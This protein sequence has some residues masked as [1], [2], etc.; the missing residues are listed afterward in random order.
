LFTCARIPVV[1]A[2][3]PIADTN[4]AAAVASWMANLTTAA[5]TY[6]NIADWNTA[7]VT[8]MAS[9]FNGTAKFNDDIGGWN[10][11]AVANMN[12]MFNGAS[13]FSRNLAGWNVLAVTDFT[14]TFDGTALSGCNYAGAIYTAWGTA[15]QTLW[16]TFNAETCT[17]ESLCT[18]CITNGNIGMAAV[19]WVTSPSAAAVTYGNIVDWNTAAVTSMGSLFASQ[20]TFNDDISSWN[21]VSVANMA[22][23]FNGAAA[24]N[25]YIGGWNVASA[26]TLDHM[27]ASATAFNQD[28]GGW[29]VASVA[30]FNSMFFSAGATFNRNIGGWNLSSATDLRYMFSSGAKWVLSSAES[31][32][33]AACAS[34]S[35]SCSELSWPTSAAAMSAAFQTVGK[36]CGTADFKIEQDAAVP[37]FTTSTSDTGQP[38]NNCYGYTGNSTRCSVAGATGSGWTRLCACVSSPAAFNQ[39]IGGWNVARVSNLYGM[40]DGAAGFSQN[41]GSWNVATVANLATALDFASGLSFGSKRAMYMGWGS[42]LQT[43]YPSWGLVDSN[44]AN[45]VTWWMNAPSTAAA[46][47]GPIGRWDTSAVTSFA[48]LFSSKPAFNDDISSWNTASVTT[49]FRMFASAA[50][51]SQEIYRWNVLSVTS[52]SAAFQDV[53]LSSCTKAFIYTAWGSTLQLEYPAWGSFSISN[54]TRRC[55]KWRHADSMMPD[56]LKGSLAVQPDTIT[57]SVAYFVADI[58]VRPC[59]QLRI[60][61]D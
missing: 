10:T 47:Y 57:D 58:G 19:A 2:Q 61:A 22:S 8:T 52:V 24:F 25:S 21:T 39:D 14:S 30:N 50:T 3:T 56:S 27:F 60:L 13:A 55:A 31:S 15:F 41:L 38:V 33:N 54:C 18:T 4:I 43:W 12:G 42:T 17:I 23:T 11:A 45:A 37:G 59:W 16:P 49:M 36:L 32:C 40:L 5:A 7:T 29:N 26:T 6:G 20:P 44:I 9:L 53:E 51:F 48:S 46:A 35:Q 34:S 1:Q 28:I